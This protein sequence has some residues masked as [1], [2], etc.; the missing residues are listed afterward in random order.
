MEESPRDWRP[1]PDPTLLTT[2]QLHRE[3]LALRELLGARLDGMD[4]AIALAERTCGQIAAYVDRQVAQLQALQDEKFRGVAQQ[5]LD[6]EARLVQTGRDGKL[7]I[8]AALQ[9]AKEAVTKSEAATTKQIDQLGELMRVSV[10]AN[11]EKID[12]VKSGLLLL[13]GREKGSTDS[14]GIVVA[15][16]GVAI[17]VGGLILAFLRLSH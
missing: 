9:A 7:A 16:V 10:Q 4:K 1:I 6:R 2:Q 17:G 11:T 14:W 15:I 8:E 12:D 13:Q 3:L 5:F